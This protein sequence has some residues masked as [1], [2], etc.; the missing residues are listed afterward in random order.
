MDIM[1]ECERCHNTS[2]VVF[3]GVSFL[4]YKLILVPIPK[5]YDGLLKLEPNG[6]VVYYCSDECATL[7]GVLI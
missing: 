2:H 3:C 5:S 1:F 7:A 4:E 6:K